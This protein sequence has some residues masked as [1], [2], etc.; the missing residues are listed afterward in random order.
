MVVLCVTLL[1][2]LLAGLWR[3]TFLAVLTSASYLSWY[4]M[5]EQFPHQLHPLTVFVLLIAALVLDL[6]WLSTCTAR[7]WRSSWVD[8][9]S[10]SGLRTF[11]VFVS[12]LLFVAEF[13]AA[14]LSA[15]ITFSLLTKPAPKRQAA[16]PN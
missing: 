8:S 10:Q 7:L 15:S 14:F 2:A 1:F 13:V 9:S 5:R 16:Q 4:F 11:T 3:P 6:S 12:Y